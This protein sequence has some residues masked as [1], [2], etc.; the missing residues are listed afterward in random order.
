MSN[1][2]TKTIE[3][4]ENLIRCNIENNGFCRIVKNNIKK[5][6]NAIISLKEVKIK[7]EIANKCVLEIKDLKIQETEYGWYIKSL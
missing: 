5:E 1:Y 4:L 2:N 3:R 7:D 6:A